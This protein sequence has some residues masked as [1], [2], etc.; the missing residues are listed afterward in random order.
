MSTATVSLH[1]MRLNHFKET[2]RSPVAGIWL[3]VLRW[4]GEGRRTLD[5]QLLDFLVY[6]DGS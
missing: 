4:L 6:L 3:Y 1:L 5:S 2:T